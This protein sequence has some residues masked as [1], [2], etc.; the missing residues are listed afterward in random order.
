MKQKLLKLMCLLCVSVMSAS[1]WGD[2]VT[3]QYSGSTTTNMD[4]TNQAAT[5]GLEATAWSVVGDKGKNSNYPGLNKD[6]D[7]RL[8]YTQGGSNTLTIS[9]LTGATITSITI[10]YNTGYENGKVLVGST[11][12]TGTNGTYNINSSSFVVTNGNTS[13]T[14]VRISNI[15]IT[16]TLS[17]AVNTTTTI[18]ATG[19][20]NTDVYTGTAA[21]SLSASVKA[22]DDAVAG[23]TVTWSGNNDAVATINATTG[24]VTLVAAGT[25]T[26]TASYAGVADEY[27]ASSATYEMTVV[28]NTPDIYIWEETA[29]NSLSATDVFVIVGENS[30]NYAMTNDNGTSSAPDAIE[31]TVSGTKITS[32]VANNM[33]WNIS[34]NATD[35]Y[36][37]YPN[38]STTTW[39]YCNTTANSSSNNNMRVGTG[40]R[41]RKV[42]ELNS[43]KLLTKDTYTGRYVSVYPDNP[44]WRG[45]TSSTAQSTTIK[46]YKATG[47]KFTVSASGYATFY[48]SEHAYIIPTGLTGYAITAVAGDKL[49]TTEYAA[50]TV[51]PA[52]EAL[53]LKGAQG[54]YDLIFTTTTNPVLATNLLK[55]SD[56]AAETTGGAK[57]YMLSFDDTDANVGFY[58]GAAEGAAFT[59]GAHKAY[60][61]LPDDT[62]VKGFRFDFDEVTAITELTEKTEATEGVIYN[63]QGQR[64]NSLQKGIN[65][66][67]GK[68]VLVK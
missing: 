18:D 22:G 17:S 33:K 53:V 47:Y 44:D 8:Y 31:V 60:L 16:Y 19:I 63:L 2:S 55:G 25:V 52:G 9:S 20:T 15:V 62:S 48:S 11:E 65:I 49:T 57:Y 35:G 54:N 29:L 42:F 64:V 28:D 58:Y 67:N 32:S 51:V 4:G 45:Y 14:Q 10:T 59:N 38:G 26:F 41:E 1:A 61:A 12:V 37:F 23:A 13:N 27:K 34:G 30:N 50:G 24:A 21:G 66:V 7:I 36:T 46:F 39:L 6:G 40:E 56:A 43:N 68:K 5:L 3:L